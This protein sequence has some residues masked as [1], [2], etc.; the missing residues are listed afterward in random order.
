[1]RAFPYIGGNLSREKKV[2]LFSLKER[3]SKKIVKK[4]TR[5]SIWDIACF[6]SVRVIETL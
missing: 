5:S 6:I 2:Y 4:G 3:K 1:M